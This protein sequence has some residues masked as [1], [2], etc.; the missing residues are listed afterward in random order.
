[1]D[2]KLLGEQGR[3]GIVGK[4]G[5]GYA[6][7]RDLHRMGAEAEGAVHRDLDKLDS[8]LALKKLAA[9]FNIEQGEASQQSLDKQLALDELKYEDEKKRQRRLEDQFYRQYMQFNRV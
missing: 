2:R 9:M 6:Q 1:M 3:R 7:R 8:D 4:G 5:V